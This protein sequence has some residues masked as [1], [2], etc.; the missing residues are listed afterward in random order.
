MSD[1]RNGDWY[2]DKKKN[3]A[4]YQLLRY[5]AKNQEDGL[6]CVGK[7]DDARRLFE[8]KGGIHVPVKNGARVIFFA[9]GEQA[10]LV[11]ASVILEVPPA[12]LTNPTDEQLK[13][14]VLGNYS[15]W[16]PRAY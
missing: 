4:V 12:R 8:D 9:P 6:R 5:I 14:F 2:D 3:G 15:Y 10:L 1:E 11:G 16:P 13:K 7:D